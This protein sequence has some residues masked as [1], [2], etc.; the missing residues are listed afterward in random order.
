MTLS[1]IFS[2]MTIR[3]TVKEQSFAVVVCM[4]EI[5]CHTPVLCRNG[6]NT[7]RLTY[8]LILLY[9][10]FTYMSKQLYDMN[11]RSTGEGKGAKLDQYAAYARLSFKEIR[12]F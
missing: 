2:R 12:V 3:E 6:C 9:V 1:I 7:V 5:V 10:I 8:G 4:C 11:A